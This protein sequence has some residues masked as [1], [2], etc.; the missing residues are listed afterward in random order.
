MHAHTKNAQLESGLG[1][2][3]SFKSIFFFYYLFFFT[4][5]RVLQGHIISMLE[6]AEAGGLIGLVERLQGAC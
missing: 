5:V 2:E 3:D 1:I 4:V 6:G